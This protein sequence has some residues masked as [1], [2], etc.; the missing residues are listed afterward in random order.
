MSFDSD[1]EDDGFQDDE[2]R[3]PVRYQTRDARYH[4]SLARSL[5]VRVDCVLCV[6]CVCV[7]RA[8]VVCVC[9]VCL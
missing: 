1:D 4:D 2:G 5:G 6:L 9:A 8:C 7:L 3:L